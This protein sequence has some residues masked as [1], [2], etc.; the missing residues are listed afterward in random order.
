MQKK[1]ELP[2]GLAIKHEE[3]ERW[4][5]DIHAV[6]L[7][8]ETLN[9]IHDIRLAFA[10]K[11]EKLEV[12]VSDRRWQKSAILLKAAAFFCGREKINL[13]D[14]LLLRHCL[15]TVKE[16]YKEVIKIVEDAVRNCG[17][18]TDF[19]LHIIDS[20]KENLENEIQ[21]ELYHSED[22][23]ETE[24]LHGNKQYFKCT[25]EYNFNRHTSYL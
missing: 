23:Y 9:V 16:N 8:E 24:N 20:E 22:I 3:W 10:E 25:R 13:V 14:T 21:K 5:N 12:Y 18:E 2:D 6:K 19:S 15:W 17:F 1:L 11:G 7:S 4:C